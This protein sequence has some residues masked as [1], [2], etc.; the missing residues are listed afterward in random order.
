VSNL[1][2]R[3]FRTALLSVLAAGLTWDGSARAQ[4]ESPASRLPPHVREATFYFLN[5]DYLRADAEL[6]AAR[7][8]GRIGQ[9]EGQADLL[10]GVLALAFGM[11]SSA[12]RAFE[13]AAH[14]GATPGERDQAW[15][16][17]AKLNH[18]RGNLAES[19]KLL[20]RIGGA[21]PGESDDERRVLSAYVAMERGDP[22][23]AVT[24][25]QAVPA[26]SDWAAYGRYNLGVALVRAGDDERGLALLDEFGRAAATGA[27]ML[28]LR[29]RAN[30][31]LGYALLRRGDARSAQ[32]ALERVRLDGLDSGKA[33]LAMGWAQ[34]QLE[35]HRRALVYWDELAR[36]DFRDS[37]V[38]EA[39]LTIP[40]TY[41]QLNARAQALVLYEKAIAAY[42]A[43]ARHLDAAIEGVRSGTF[44]DELL[45]ENRQSVA[46]T[47]FGDVDRLPVTAATPYL[48]T[49]LASNEVQDALRNYR[50]LV[51][52]R[53]RMSEWSGK[54]D[55][56]AMMV[57]N[58]RAAQAQ[59]GA[60]TGRESPDARLDRCR[61]SRDDL[62]AALARLEARGSDS[63][64]LAGARKHLR[65]LDAVLA[66]TGERRRALQRARAQAAA[67]NADFAARIAD[68][69]ARVARLAPKIDE[70]ISDQ[71]RRIE[72]LIVRELEFK[73]ERLSRYRNE[74]RLAVAEIYDAAAQ[75]AAPTPR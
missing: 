24:L 27:E 6:A 33:L 3:A 13:R 14:D 55:T 41:G 11:E 50:E 5:A 10:E 8:F 40:Y 71:R 9:A 56:L 35:R 62:A 73:K 65:E 49:L 47:W 66:R 60:D 23:R 74:A 52:L 22:K 18:R 51:A 67:T 37:E 45:R 69:R 44:L 63:A 53:H 20:A 29:D 64:D 75:P 36:R 34:S 21:L 19:E 15:F 26:Q 43:E 57:E 48:G 16:Q 28:A 59:P 39:W 17:L 72:R 25:L 30:M 54:T 2:H 1:L 46:D 4:D 61:R 68:A 32:R 70:A 42:D 58:R 38:Q 31:A 12:A 7:R